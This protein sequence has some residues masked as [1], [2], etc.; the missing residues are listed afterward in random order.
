MK[1]ATVMTSSLLPTSAVPPGYRPAAPL[2][3]RATSNPIGVTAASSTNI[4]YL[5]TNISQ[6]EV[7]G[8]LTGQDPTDMYNFTYQN[9]GPVTLTLRQYRRHRAGARQTAGWQ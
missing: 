8:Q 3:Q 2:H 4:G 7:I 6:F 9:S 1:V 5:S